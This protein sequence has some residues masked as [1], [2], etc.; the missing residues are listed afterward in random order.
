MKLKKQFE[1]FYNEIRI[2]DESKPLKEKREILQS[3]IESKLPGKL[4]E[5]DI[6]LNKSDIEMFDQGSFKLHTTIK[7]TVIDRDV[8]V[9]IPLNID[10]NPDPRKIKG[11]VRDALNYVTNRTVNIKE[12]CV[13]VTYFEDGEEWMHIDLPLYATYNG[14]VYLARGREYGAIYSWEPADPKGLN[15]DLLEKINGNEQLRRVIRYIKKWKNEKYKNSTLDH[16]VPPSIG[17][18]YLA[19]DCFVAVSSTEGEDDLSSLQQTMAA[20]KNKFLKTYENGI[21]VKADISKYLPV[22]PFTD[23]FKTMKDASDDYGVTFYKKLDTAVQNLIDACNESSEHDAGVSVQK[24]FGDEFIA[25][26]KAVSTSSASSK[27]EH[28]FG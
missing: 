27:K 18:T 14:N 13:N 20:I 16:E 12:P 5:Y 22:T 25:P 2:T 21:L 26:P 8:A 6:D 4:K 17:L 1:D 23:I 11:Y 28:S 15:N 9:M 3:D 10:D 24:V 7:D 19:C